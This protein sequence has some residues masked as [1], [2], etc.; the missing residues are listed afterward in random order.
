MDMSLLSKAD[1]SIDD[2]KRKQVTIIGGGVAGMLLAKKI[3]DIG[4]D[5]A[6]IEKSPVF[7]NGPSTRNEGWLHR[8]TYHATSIF[9]RN[10]ALQVARR[11]IYG[12]EQIKQY[13]P[14]AIEDIATPSYCVLTNKERIN[15][16]ESR[17]KEAGVQ[18]A[19]VS[20]QELLRYAP[21]IRHL[22]IESA[23]RVADIGVHTRILYQKIL[24]DCQR[25]DVELITNAN[26]HFEDPTTLTIETS[27]SKRRIKS[28]L[29]VHTSGY[30]MGD[31]FKREFGI[32]IGLRYW[33]SH[34][35]VTPR[36]AEASVF[37]LEPLGAAAMNHG[38]ISIVGLNEDAQRCES[39]SS[40]IDREQI[41]KHIYTVRKFFQ[42]SIEQYLPIACTKV[43]RPLTEQ[44][45]DLLR[46]HSTPRSLN[47]CL[48]EPIKNHICALPGKMTEAPYLVD[49]LLKI[50]FDRIRSDTV[51]LRPCDTWST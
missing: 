22:D 35:L 27:A 30:E 5:T 24:T 2:F 33:K 45:T 41:E 39:P 6:V 48:F 12:Y 32:D 29:F 38:G 18:F 46:E 20:H 37:S 26:S 16:V 23:Y 49:G 13:A 47:I 11:C 21:T 42:E 17:W 1:D 28:D 51:A 43:D 34:L 9:D 7:G 10:I 50:I 19:H 44:G 14:E 25:N 8:G 4:I 40:E 36:L 31:F 15:E 3:S